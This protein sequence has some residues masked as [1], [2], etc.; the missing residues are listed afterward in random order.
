MRDDHEAA[1]VAPEVVAQPGDRVGVE[2]VGGLVEEQG[3][4]TRV[5]DAG[6]L[7]AAALATGERAEGLAEHPL[8]EAEGPGDRR[9]LGLGGIPAGRGELRLEPAVAVHGAVLLLPRVRRHGDLGGSQVAHDR[10]EPTRREDA[11]A[12]QDAEV[13]AT[14]V[15]R[16]VADR[17]GPGD[18][19]G[20]GLGDTREGLGESRLPG[21]VATDETHPVTGRDA[22]RRV[23]EEQAG[24]RAQLDG[25]SGDHEV[26]FGGVAGNDQGGA[27]GHGDGRST[28]S[29]GAAA[30]RAVHA[31]GDGGPA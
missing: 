25:G 22:E 13:D 2:V 7:D 12:R 19:T 24:A 3:L 31:P 6:E 5:Q 26:P 1:L 15:L 10:V 20:G 30:R 8:V 9:G 4:G 29:L 16:Q 18:R 28:S 23:V 27:G 14:G 11:V 21:A 17:A